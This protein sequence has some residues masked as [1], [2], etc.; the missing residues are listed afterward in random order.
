MRPGRQW[1]RMVEA[2]V[3]GGPWGAGFGWFPADAQLPAVVDAAPP[4][5]PDDVQWLAADV[6]ARRDGRA[7]GGTEWTKPQLGSPT[8]LRPCGGNRPRDPPGDRPL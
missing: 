3:A 1:P 8:T 6:Q 7:S 4:E 5:D 2:L